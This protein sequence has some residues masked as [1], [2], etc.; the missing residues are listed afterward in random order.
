MSGVKA[1]GLVSAAGLSSRMGAFK[2]ALDLCGKPLICRTVESLLDSG[3]EQ[4]IV[5]TGR[6]AGQ[7]KEM[8]DVY[9]KV[10]TVQNERFAD[11]S[12]YESVRLGLQQMEACDAVLFLPADIPA[13]RPES[14]RL[15]LEQWNMKKTDVLFPVYQNKRWHPPVIAGRL[16]PDLLLYSGEKG[17]R[18]A[19]E[20]LTSSTEEMVVPDPGCTMDADYMEEY[21]ALCHYW[22]VRDIPD[23]EVCKTL[24]QLAE[25]PEEVQKHCEAVKDKALELSNSLKEHGIYMNEELL[26]AAACLHDVCRNRE[27]HAE[28]DSEFL[29]QYGFYRVA[30]LIEIH[31]DWPE[32]RIIQID[33]AAI[34]YLADKLVSGNQAVSLEQR[35]AEKIRRFADNPDVA[36]MIKKRQNVALEIQRQVEEICTQNA[37]H[38]E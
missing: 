31:M 29:R 34:L 5:V 24:Y 2:P 35:F 32:Q 37:M 15:L 19:L 14:I 23:T 30:D 9:S 4:V 25:T 8:L 18:G 13:I 1:A 28:A 7:L 3:I 11:T 10:K 16:I 36:E 22:P 6:N 38:M 17:L 26:Y 20:S 12:M 33:E 27:N 21:Q